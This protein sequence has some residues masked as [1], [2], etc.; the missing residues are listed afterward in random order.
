MTMTAVAAQSQE[1]VKITVAGKITDPAFHKCVTAVKYLQEQHPETVSS[2]CLAFFET[3]WEEYIK[4]TANKLK[5]VF[6]HHAGNHLILLND[7][8]YV[9]NSE[10]FAT[11]ILHRFAYMDNSM[12]VVYER[13]AANQFKKMI[14]TSKTR[15]Y[16]KL[17]ITF[18]N[19]TNTVYF[20]LFNDI[21]PR[22]VANFL[23]LCNGHTRSDGEKLGY[24]GTEVHRV[25]NGMFLQMGR[26]TPSKAPELGCSVYGGAFEDESFHIKHT[27][28]GLLGMCKRNG[29]GHSNESQFYVTMGAP[30]T[31]LDNKN[32]IFGRVIQGMRCLKLIEKL[33]TLNEKPAESVKIVGAGPYSVQ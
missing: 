27:E 33:D 29:S 31:F 11:Y 24:V 1:P 26:I 20:E 14:N 30:L 25:V 7:E 28:I 13:L 32:V 6:Y 21:A 15:K 3:Q 8:E 9:G 2:E 22:T 4:R 19:M 18:N 5:G 12:N 16:A 23:G 10:Q 17:D